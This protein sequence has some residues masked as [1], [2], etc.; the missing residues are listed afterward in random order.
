MSPAKSIVQKRQRKKTRARRFSLLSQKD[1]QYSRC[2]EKAVPAERVHVSD[3]EVKPN[4]HTGVFPSLVA[5]PPTNHQ[6]EIKKGIE[7]VV[8]KEVRR[9]VPATFV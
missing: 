5:R 7:H 1:E 8:D 3:W 6:D 4:H 2:R 9:R